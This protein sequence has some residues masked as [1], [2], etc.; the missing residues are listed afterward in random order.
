MYLRGKKREIDGKLSLFFSLSFYLVY[1]HTF[2]FSF[3]LL[4]R[5]S[6]S[7]CV[8]SCQG[9]SISPISFSFVLHTSAASSLFA[10][11]E[12]LLLL[13]CSLFLSVYFASAIAARK[14]SDPLNNN[15]NTHKQKTDPKKNKLFRVSV[16]CPLSRRM[17]QDDLCFA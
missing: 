4:V 6:V 15:N 10:R 17:V 1:T 5:V 13:P 12:P 16:F 11:L 9:E 7:C 2:C 8:C 14:S 3:F